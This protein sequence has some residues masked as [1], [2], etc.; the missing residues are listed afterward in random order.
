MIFNS[1]K[2]VSIICCVIYSS[3]MSHNLVAETVGTNAEKSIEAE[4]QIEKLISEVNRY[5]GDGNGVDKRTPQ[6]IV[7]FATNYTSS[8]R[9]PLKV[10]EQYKEKIQNDTGLKIE[11]E[12]D[13]N[14]RTRTV[15]FKYTGVSTSNPY[16]SEE[17]QKYSEKLS[18]SDFERF[19]KSIVKRIEA[20]IDASE[21]RLLTEIKKR[22][23]LNREFL[24]KIRDKN[25]DSIKPSELIGE[26]II[27]EAVGN[28]YIGKPN[29][30]I[31]KEE[32]KNVVTKEKKE[33]KLG[34]N[35]AKTKDVSVSDNKVSGQL[36]NGVGENIHVEKF[37]KMYPLY[38]GILTK[39][40]SIDKLKELSLFDLENHT[41]LKNYWEDYINTNTFKRRI[42]EIT[43]ND[44]KDAVEYFT[45]RE[46]DKGIKS[47][48]NLVLSE[49]SP[50]D[51]C[52]LTE[53]GLKQTLNKI[54]ELAKFK[55]ENVGQTKK[56]TAAYN[57]TIADA[58]RGSKLNMVDHEKL[59]IA[60]ERR[61][62]AV[63]ERNEKLGL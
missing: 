62:K 30:D 4:S 21:Q 9:I 51:A 15:K 33:T 36:V 24:A 1:L 35:D 8:N 57:K 43:D 5:K 7:V 42:I 63:R 3:F 52:M 32:E 37:A 25:S 19:E 49:R 26:K 16:K 12:H 60:N 41:Y 40:Y 20:L 29:V 27:K 58:N 47:E 55:G 61:N 13:K 39:Q 53:S 50:K 10:I 56:K 17:I 46:N 44:V 28:D 48:L 18:S 54:Y 31:I 34:V 11:S 23:E 2:H 45:E 22:Y 59:K 14:K 38:Y 6:D